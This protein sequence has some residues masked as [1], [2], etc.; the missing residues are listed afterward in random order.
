MNPSTTNANYTNITQCYEGILD[1]GAVVLVFPPIRKKFPKTDYLYLLYADLL[2]KDS[3]QYMVKSINAIQHILLPFYAMRYRKKIAL[4]Y[5]WLEFQDLKSLLAFPY[6]LFWFSTFTLF[7]I[8]IIWTV[9]N[10][11]PHDR[12]WLIFHQWLH[13]KMAQRA[14]RLHIHDES[15]LSD[16]SHY[17]NVSLHS[18]KWCI[19]PHPNFPAVPKD[20][21]LSINKLNKRYSVNIPVDATT[22]LLFGNISAYKGILEFLEG[23]IGYL[24]RKNSGH[25]IHI[26]IAGPVKKGQSGYHQRIKTTISASPEYFTYLPYFFPEDEYPYLLSASDYCLFNYKSIHTSGGFMMALSY[27]RKVIAPNIGIF[28][29]KRD[30]DNK[31]TKESSL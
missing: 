27:H 20:R 24:N 19:V 5:H 1:H 28:S 22:I 21:S 6:K 15:L 14:H 26:I 7:K 4:H 18:K 10:L 2:E 17:L 25:D 30:Q 23:M 16:T 12:K 8:P 3:S 11:E 31:S 9:H 13:R 29:S